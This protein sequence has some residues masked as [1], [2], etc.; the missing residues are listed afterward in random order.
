MKISNI[1]YQISKIHIKIKNF[2]FCSPACGGQVI[3]I[4]AFC[5][6][7]I[8]SG[9]S[10]KVS[11]RIE[12]V[13]VEVV[14]AK[15]ESLKE[16]LFYVGDIK[17]EDEATVYPKVTGK[18]IEKSAKEGDVVK[19]GI[20][21]AYIDRD[22]VGFKFEKAPVES[23]IDGIVGRIYVDIGT[24]VSP[25]T[26]IGLVVNMEIVKVKIDVAEKDLS[27]IKEGQKVKI[28]ADAYSGEVF[29]GV[30]EKVSPIVDVDSRTAPVEIKIPN[31]KHKLK[32]GMFAR[33]EI[34]LGEVE[35]AIVVPRE[36]VMAG[37][38]ENFLFV[39][40]SDKADKRKVVLG[41]EKLDKV[42]I[43]QGLEPGE[44]VVIKGQQRLKDDLPIEI[45]KEGE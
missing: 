5:I 40:S 32:P 2:T 8:L 33:T 16:S 30:V 11:E 10:R 44:R 45:V 9:C 25:Q 36:A 22:E 14:Q 24:S 29:E 43:I 26:P 19:K 23:P 20:P 31:L 13:P 17:A 21:L 41:I 4:F 28:T 12:K 6:L 18:I 35:D 42:Q 27:K 1:K 38:D 3:L 34:I 15:I 37:L 7:Q 39:A